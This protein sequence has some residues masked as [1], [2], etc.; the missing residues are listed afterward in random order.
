M[1]NIVAAQTVS[2]LNNCSFK[3]F[4]YRMIFWYEHVD[5][6]IGY[7]SLQKILL[8]QGVPP[9]AIRGNHSALVLGESFCTVKQSRQGSK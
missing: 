6:V 2:P 7:D 5:I 9:T 1:N 4:E 8:S 3:D